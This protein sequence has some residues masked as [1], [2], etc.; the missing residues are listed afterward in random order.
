MRCRAAALDLLSYEHGDI[1]GILFSPRIGSVRVSLLRE[2]FVAAKCISLD[3]ENQKKCSPVSIVLRA[4]SC[5]LVDF[6]LLAR[7]SSSRHMLVEITK[8]RY[9]GGTL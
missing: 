4:R 5:T 8:R 1:D 9:V 2:V 7:S 3:P 6:G